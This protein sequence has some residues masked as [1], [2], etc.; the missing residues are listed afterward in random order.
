MSIRTLL[1]KDRSHTLYITAFTM[2]HGAQHASD[3][4]SNERKDGLRPP[5]PW[6]S[7]AV[8]LFPFSFL[9]SLS[10]TMPAPGAQ[11][12]DG[13]RNTILCF[14]PLKYLDPC[15]QTPQNPSQ[16]L[17]L[18]TAHR[19]PTLV[20][21]LILPFVSSDVDRHEDEPFWITAHLLQEALLH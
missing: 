10:P 4:D 13:T 14:P 17:L 20:K 15:A 5:L 8:F 9:P 2:P 21:M 11:H 3:D 1:I 6:K 16:P 18:T 7:P 19:P 12:I